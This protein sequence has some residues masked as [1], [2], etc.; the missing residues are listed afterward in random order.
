MLDTLINNFQNFVMQVRLSYALFM[1]PRVPVLPKMIPI[2]III[3]LLTPIDIVPD[4]LIGLGQLDDVV[5]VLAG[6]EFFERNVPRHIATEH[7]QR[8]LK[9]Q[10]E[11]DDQRR[12]QQ[13]I[14][15]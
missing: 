9:E 14:S 2:G 8:L 12:P 4:F 5:I 11:K 13:E 7:R 15:E 6:L 1:D 3:Y 10:A